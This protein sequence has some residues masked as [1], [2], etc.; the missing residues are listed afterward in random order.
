MVSNCLQ[1]IGLA[2]EDGRAFGERTGAG[3]HRFLVMPGQG[4]A[5]IGAA[6]LRTVAVRQ[7]VMDAESRIHGADRLTG[8]GRI[9]G[10]GGAF[11]NFAVVCRKSIAIPLV[12]RAFD[13][14]DEPFG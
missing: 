6:A 7:A 4:A 9:D 14:V 12:I 2:A 1:Q 5:V 8:L 11:G 10:Q 13:S 3:H